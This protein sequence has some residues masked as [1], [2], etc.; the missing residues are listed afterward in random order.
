MAHDY[1]WFY[2]EGSPHLSHGEIESEDRRLRVLGL[3]QQACVRFLEHHLK[4]RILQLSSKDLLAAIQEFAD[5]WLVAIELFSHAGKLRPLAAEQEC[6][7]GSGVADDAVMDARFGA[8]SGK[9]FEAAGDLVAC[10]SGDGQ[11]VSPMRPSGICSEAEIV[12]VGIATAAEI[13][14]VAA[15]QLHEGRRGFS[16][17]RQCRGGPP[18]RVGPVRLRRLSENGVNVGAAHAKRTDACVPRS[19]IAPPGNR[20]T[21]YFDGKGIPRDVRAGIFE[22]EVRRNLAMVKAKRRLNHSSNSCRGFEMPYICFHGAHPQRPVGAPPRAER[23]ANRLHFDR[24]AKDG[25]SSVC[26]EVADVFGNNARIGH[27][28]ANHCLLSPAVGY[29]QAAARPVVIHGASM[30]HGIDPIPILHGG[31]KALQDHDATPFPASVSIG[32][33]IEGFAPAVRRQRTH[34]AENQVCVRSQ[35]E[36]DSPCDRDVALPAPDALRRQVQSHQ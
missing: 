30:E 5:Y 35:H 23:M 26:F 20:L 9:C 21:R 11:P 3:V 12:Q 10:A 18:G 36:I 34:T 29:G 25:A 14:S 13:L 16:R 7:F 8:A 2:S 6:N 17:H 4:Q 32:G 19:A 22:M 28:C 1:R 33:G 31:G 27:G 15:C 24:V